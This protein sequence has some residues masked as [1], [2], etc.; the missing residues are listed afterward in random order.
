MRRSSA[1]AGAVCLALVLAACETPASLAKKRARLVESGLL[2]SVVLKGQRPEKLSL[3]SR[4]RFYRIPGASLA[5]MDRHGLEWARAYGLLDVSGGGPVSTQTL[6]RADALLRPIL[7]AASLR[8]AASGKLGLDGD[9]EKSDG[10]VLGEILA[11]EVFG[12]LGLSSI[13]FG[14]AP[15]VLDGKE[16]A[17]GHGRDGKPWGEAKGTGPGPASALWT[18]PS[19]VILFLSDILAS[20]MGRSGRLLEAEAAR[21][22]L[23]PESAPGAAGFAVAGSG[24]DVRL[25]LRGRAEGFSAALEV[26]PYRGQG[27]VVLTNSDNGL[28]LTDEILRAVSAVYEWPD[29]KVREKT[30][31]RLDPSVYASYVG[32]YEITPD[33]VLDVTYEDYYLIIRP[34]GQAPTRFYV[35]SP[36]IFYSVDPDITV[37]FLSGPDGKVSGL[38]LWQQDFKQEARKVS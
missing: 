15:Q 14:P 36:T 10:P 7:A 29:F 2:R 3:P 25:S 31:Y 22:M 16:A 35:E 38:I 13:A 12:P 11:A 33:Y 26:Y 24:S 4:L 20:A 23:A 9:I 34:T 6:F 27:A 5:V 17:S 8:R 28:L 21:R 1:A 30:A 18:S 19:D 37:Q 32:R